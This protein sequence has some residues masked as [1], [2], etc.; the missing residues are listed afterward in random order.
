MSKKKTTKPRTTP[1]KSEPVVTGVTRGGYTGIDCQKC[2]R[3]RVEIDGVCE[4]CGHIA[5]CH[6]CGS[7]ATCFGSYEGKEPAFGCDKCCG[8][9]CEDGKCEKLVERE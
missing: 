1:A 3:N 5:T 6:T 7:E 2:G 8:H 4:K 9:W